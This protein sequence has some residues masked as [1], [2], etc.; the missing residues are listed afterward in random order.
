MPQVECRGSLHPGQLG[1]LVGTNSV[2]CTHCALQA[3][4]I[5]LRNSLDVDIDA[6]LCGLEQKIVFLRRKKIATNIHTLI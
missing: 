2:E 4:K 3:H 1:A 6:D 5:K